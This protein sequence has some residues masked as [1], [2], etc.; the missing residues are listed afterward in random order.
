MSLILNQQTLIGRQQLLLGQRQ[1]DLLAAVSQLQSEQTRLAA[2]ED[3]RA[4]ALVR[5]MERHHQRII[6]LLDNVAGPDND[7]PVADN[8]V[9]GSPTEQTAMAQDFN[10]VINVSPDPPTHPLDSM[11]ELFHFYGL[12]SYSAYSNTIDSN[13]RF[14]RNQTEESTLLSGPIAD[15]SQYTSAS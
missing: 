7:Q 4:R 2:R 6:T 10:C 5:R 12:S 1:L 8:S 13:L 11:N 9:P 14:Y 3:A 15:S